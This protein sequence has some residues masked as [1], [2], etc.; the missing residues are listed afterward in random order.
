M[1]YLGPL[2]AGGLT[3]AVVLVVGIFSFLPAQINQT[4]NAEAAPAGQR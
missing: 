3:I 4:T 2:L 1:K